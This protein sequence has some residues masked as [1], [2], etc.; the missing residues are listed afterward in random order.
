MADFSVILQSPTIRRLVQEGILE[1]AFHDALFPKLLFRGEAL[2]QKWP[3]NVGD[4]AIFTGVGLI[5]PKLRPLQPGNDPTPSEYPKEQW[6]ASILQYADSIDTHMPTSINAIAN[7]F[8]RNAQ[9]LGLGAGMSLNR[10]VRNQLYNASLSGHTV[11]DGALGPVATIRVKRLNGFTTARR[12]DLANGEPVRFDPVSG[13]NP[14]SIQIFDT[15][16]PAFVTRAVTSFTADNAGDEIGPGTITFTGGNVTVLDR[17]AVIADDRARLVR[18]GGGNSV[19][20]VGSNDLLRLADIR[21]AVARFWQTN[22]PEQPDGR[23]HCHL[24][25]TSQSQ[26][27]GDPEFQRL[28]TSLPDHYMYADFALGQ[29]LG[30]VF[31]RNSENPLAET[32]ADGDV[33]AFDLD[34]PFAGELTALGTAAGTPIHRPLFVGQGGILEYWQDLMAL[35]TEAGVAGKVGEFDINNNGIDVYTDRIQLIIRQP[36]NR[37]QDMV[38]SSWK[39]IG[40]W[41]VRTDVTTGDA[42]RYKREL[43]IEHGE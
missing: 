38:S 11:A 26:V 40:D 12:P 21:A 28:L 9:Q 25:P 35:I 6:T 23:F 41:P 10:L 24:D 16:G 42:A 17:A 31:F 27:F 34:D 37:L 43:V 15:A 19:D 39:F 36:L 22:V 5:K 30:T 2:P 18:V 8:L 4:S 33:T 13:N 3:E 1:R 7:L 20:S 32:V 14:L 29:L